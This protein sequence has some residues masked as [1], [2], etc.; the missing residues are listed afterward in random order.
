LE[1]F[2]DVVCEAPKPDAPFMLP[3]VDERD[4]KPFDVEPL[5]LP[6][7]DRR[8]GLDVAEVPDPGASWLLAASSEPE[9][10]PPMNISV[11]TRAIWRASPYFTW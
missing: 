8:S 7:I 11:S 1:P 6:F 9:D 5:L 10:D 2:A 3:P 4:P